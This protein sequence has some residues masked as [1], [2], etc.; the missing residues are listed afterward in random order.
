MITARLNQLRA[1]KRLQKDDEAKRTFISYL[2]HELRTPLHAILTQTQYLIGYEAL[3]E[4]QLDKIAHIENASQQ[5]LSMISDLLDLAKLEA[6][7]YDLQLETVNCEDVVET[8]D[9]LMQMLAPLAE[10]K[11]LR[12]TLTSTRDNVQCI[13]DLRLLRRVVSNLLSNAIKFTE[14]GEI[15][16]RVTADTKEIIITVKDSGCGIEK[17]AL[18]TLCDPFVQYGDASQIEKGSGIGLALS[19][20][21][22]TLFGATLEIES[23]GLGE[24]TTATVVITTI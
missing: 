7:K 11:E 14:T 21:Y 22:S 18:S 2:S 3:N 4:T 8:V 5:L 13:I 12:Y 17:K 6:G 15:A 24:G 20:R 10:Q 9:T 23:E 19:Q 1:Y 16:C